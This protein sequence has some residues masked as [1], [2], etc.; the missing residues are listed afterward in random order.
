MESAVSEFVCLIVSLN[1]RQGWT[2]ESLPHEDGGMVVEVQE[3]DLAIVALENHD[4]G[5]CELVC[6]HDMR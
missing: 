4:E 3:S 6:L 2:V 5:I 1:C